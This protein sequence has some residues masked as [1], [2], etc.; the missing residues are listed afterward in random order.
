MSEPNGA[1]DVDVDGFA[2]VPRSLEIKPRPRCLHGCLSIERAFPRRSEADSALFTCHGCG[3]WVCLC[4]GTA[5]ALLS[6][7]ICPPCGTLD[8]DG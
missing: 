5:P 1:L 6:G 7:W 2:T 3:N 8:V 4:C